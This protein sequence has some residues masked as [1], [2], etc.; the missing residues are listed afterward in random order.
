MAPELLSQADNWFCFHLLSE[1]DAGTLGKYNSHYSH[2]I[3]AHL[4]GE[5]IQGNCYMWSAP[6][7]PF[8][9]PVR[10]RRF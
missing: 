6:K 2:D 10:I 3:L 8:V 5:P 4:I 7:Q 9:F 1:G